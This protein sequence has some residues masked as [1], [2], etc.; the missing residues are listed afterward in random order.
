MNQQFWKMSAKWKCV[1]FFQSSPSNKHVE[2]DKCLQMWRQQWN[3]LMM[4]S[5]WLGFGKPLK[6]HEF[7]G[8]SCLSTSQGY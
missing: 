7:G 1:V 6:F 4:Q 8:I 2:D 3:L 5:Y